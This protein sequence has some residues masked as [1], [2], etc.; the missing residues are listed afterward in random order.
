M[1]AE[2][3]AR[4]GAVVL[5]AGA[6]RRLGQPKQLLV[7]SDQPLLE[8]A[9]DA[10]LSD[11]RIWP[12][13]VVLGAEA[14]VVRAA[15]AR[16]PVLFAE[17]AA[18]AEGMASS[19]RAGLATLRQFSREVDAVFCALCDQ[20]AFDGH[21]VRQLLD[22]RETTGA[23]VV[24]ARYAGHPGAPAIFSR[25]HFPALAQLTGDAGARQLFN[26]L[27]PHALATVDLP[28]LGFDVD[29]PADLQRLR[30]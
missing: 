12:V 11:P 24:A 28:Q 17:N 1:T 5:A 21:V 26:S 6:S 19:L 13:V 7:V 14:P 9:V 20:P 25:E 30:S 8:R 15:V 23:G 22:R 10:L 27:P 4:I 18:W 2:R 16:R 3:P 29:T